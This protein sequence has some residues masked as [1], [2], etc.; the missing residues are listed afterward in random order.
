M[1]YIQ[2]RIQSIKFNKKVLQ[3]ISS[4]SKIIFP[5]KWHHHKQNRTWNSVL[6]EM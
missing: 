3:M 4:A 1:C 2:A 5:L 6:N